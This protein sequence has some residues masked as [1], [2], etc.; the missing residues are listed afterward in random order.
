MILPTVISD[1]TAFDISTKFISFFNT[2]LTVGI[3]Y[4]GS[5]PFFQPLKSE[6]TNFLISL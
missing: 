6:V 1:C 4:S 2:S 5:F 3:S